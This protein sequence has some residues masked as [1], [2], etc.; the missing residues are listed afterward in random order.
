MRRVISVFRCSLPSGRSGPE[1][2]R[3]TPRQQRG[4]RWRLRPLQARQSTLRRWW[5]LAAVPTKAAATPAA[6]S[7]PTTGC[8]TQS[9][10]QPAPTTPP[11]CDRPPQVLPAAGRLGPQ[12]PAR[13]PARAPEPAREVLPRPA[14]TPLRRPRRRRNSQRARGWKQGGHRFPTLQHS[15]GPLPIVA[16]P[17]LLLAAEIIVAM[18]HGDPPEPGAE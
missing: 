5:A 12:T 17:G 11:S 4:G 10:F 9:A 7:A 6:S 15:L 1:R 3:S 2:S 18:V 8:R 16:D 13:P 14:A